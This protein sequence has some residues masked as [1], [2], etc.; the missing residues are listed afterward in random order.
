M[1]VYGGK[2]PENVHI[3]HGIQANTGLDHEKVH[4]YLNI[5]ANTGY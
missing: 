1:P 2:D 4:I 3:Y 5:Q